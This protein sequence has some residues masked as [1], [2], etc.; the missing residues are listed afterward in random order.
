MQYM[1]N[2]GLHIIMLLFLISYEGLVSPLF[3]QQSVARVTQLRLTDGET[4]ALTFE[5]SGTGAPISS[6]CHNDTVWIFADYRIVHSDGSVGAW[7]SASITGVSILSGN[8]SVVDHSLTG[9]GF[10]LNGHTA[11]GTFASTTVKITLAEPKNERFNACVYVSDCPPNA[12]MNPAGGYT[13]NGTPPFIINRTIYEP[14]RTF[15]AGTCITSITDST[16]CPGFVINRPFDA[17]EIA[18][19]GESICAGDTPGVIGGTTPAS[20]GDSNIGYRWYKDGLQISGAAGENYTP[21][22]AD[23]FTAGVHTYTRKAYDHTCHTEPVVSRGVW[24]LTVNAMPGISAPGASR[25][26]AGTVSLTAIPTGV[27]NPCTY[28]WTVGATTETTSAP[29]WTSPTI[30]V[31][32][33]YRVTVRQSAGCSATATGQITLRSKPT[34]TLNSASYTD[35]QGVPQGFPIN[36]IQYSIGN[37]AAGTGYTVTDLP[38][39]VTHT[40]SSNNIQISGSPTVSSGTFNYVVTITDPDPGCAGNS[41][42]GTIAVYTSWNKCGISYVSNIADEGM[43]TWTPASNV[44]TAKGAGW[45]L[46]T[47]TELECMCQNENRS[48]LPGGYTTQAPYWSGYPDSDDKYFVV[49]FFSN[50]TCQTSSNSTSNQRSVKCV[51][52]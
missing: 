18:S 42:T 20:G 51:K 49:Y 36:P 50:G 25:C 5:V 34:L 1:K 39:G 38:P 7:T 32:T 2:G 16:G 33:T 47:K 15:G 4:P 28:T 6:P 14:S 46:P 40:L 10:F 30:S 19:S 24:T 45:R 35:N 12:T 44:C 52:P 13:L 17:G 29:D 8:G 37:R 21:P 11:F 9:R 31:S 22:P 48:T 23:A 43:N 3:S 27:T 41:E 26:G